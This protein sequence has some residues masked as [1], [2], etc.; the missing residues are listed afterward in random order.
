MTRAPTAQASARSSLTFATAALAAPR[1]DREPSRRASATESAATSERLGWQAPASAA[2][3]PAAYRLRRRGDASRASSP[4]CRRSRS[5]AEGYAESPPC[6][7]VRRKAF[8]VVA[9]QLAVAVRTAWAVRPASAARP[10]AGAAHADSISPKSGCAR[11]LASKEEKRCPAAESFSP[12]TRKLIDPSPLR[13]PPR[14]R[15]AGDAEPLR[16]DSDR[17]A[18]RKLS[19]ELDAQLVGQR[20]RPP[21]H[22]GPL[23][24]GIA[25]SCFS[26]RRSP[27]E[28]RGLPLGCLPS[29]AR[30]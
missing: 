3:A 7:R 10:V 15:S 13:E 14:Q 25:R 4:S 9:R 29:R 19:L 28:V 1:D 23:A 16:R 17:S 30:R 27:P 22:C 12:G 26:R 5:P 20:S 21:G 11:R 24:R 18:R 6:L 8:L 2:S